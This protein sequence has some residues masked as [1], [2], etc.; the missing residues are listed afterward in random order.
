MPQKL[1]ELFNKEF[2]NSN[3][4]TD[5]APSL[6]IFNESNEIDVEFSEKSQ[7]EK[8]L[9]ENDFDSFLTSSTVFSSVGNEAG[10]GKKVLSLDGME[11]GT[12]LFNIISK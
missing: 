6:L 3:D 11:E 1:N 2:F 8:R 5:I 7:T 4:F 9:A 10:I 12:L